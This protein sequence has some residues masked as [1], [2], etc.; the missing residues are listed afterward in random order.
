MA[1]PL[2]EDDIRFYLSIEP[3]EESVRKAV[4]QINRDIER[5]KI[6]KIRME[7]EGMRAGPQPEPPQ[8]FLQK[9]FGRPGEIA[10]GTLDKTDYG[11]V[12][13]QLT[14]G[15]K[16]D[17]GFGGAVKGMGKQ[18]G[19]DLKSIWHG[20][21]GG[22]G[23]KAG[24]AVA[25]AAGGGAG[26]LAKV[27]AGAAAGAAAGGP[28]GVAI[29]VASELAKGIGLLAAA[30]FQTI[31]KG[32]GLV[33]NGLQDMQGPL[34]GIGAGLNL[35]SDLFEMAADG[36]KKVPIIGQLLGPLLDQL[37]KMPKILGQIMQVGVQLAE[38]ANPGVVRQLSLA[39]G[40]AMAT[41]GQAF[42]PMI[43]E[44]IPIIREIG[45]IIAQALPSDE[46]MRKMFRGLFESI[47]DLVK[48][49]APLAGPLLKIIVGIVKFMV[50]GL[51]MLAK[52]FHFVY[53]AVR[54]VIKG[55][56]LGL[57]DLGK[58]KDDSA[59]KKREAISAARPAWMGG[60]QEYQ[61]RLQ[62]Q[63]ATG[64]A[65]FGK[66]DVPRNV[67]NLATMVGNIEKWFA[68]MTPQQFESIIK[69]GRVGPNATR[70]T[71]DAAERM[72]R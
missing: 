24:G 44:M 38:K 17:E 63:T 41:I 35:A 58:L 21:T 61:Q 59:P 19:A 46:E 1:E 16:G 6:S 70:Q 28:V 64:P 23:A 7:I 3:D 68:K 71:V 8:H 37:A 42:I 55:L 20:L 52:A 47:R 18:F 69:S 14:R 48:E 5:E 39:L 50:D 10:Q 62:M 53:E 22:G 25:A 4:E 9:K 15:L 31:N 56:T 33:R 30:P 13:R 27:G 67:G 11:G 12:F 43:E 45:T 26:M 60:I 72:G 51:T 49:L 36:I 66:E 65:G 29:A 57:V 54:L 34:G 40:D 2:T 32:L